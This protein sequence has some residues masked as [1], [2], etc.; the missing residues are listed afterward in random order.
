MHKR[1]SKSSAPPGLTAAFGRLELPLLD[2]AVGKA[3][4]LD[5]CSMISEDTE[6]VT[7]DEASSSSGDS[8]LQVSA[9]DSPLVFGKSYS[10]PAMF[11][12]SAASEP[13]DAFADACSAL[14]FGKAQSTQ[15]AST[16]HT[17]S[18]STLELR[19]I[20]KESRC[21]V[22]TFAGLSSLGSLL[23]GTGH[24]KPCAWFWKTPGCQNEFQCRHCHSC[25]RDALKDRRRMKAEAFKAGFLQPKI[26]EGMRISL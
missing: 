24:C 25:P 3:P 19:D 1:E 20:F 8:A 14:Q 23:H 9:V 4:S 12:G 5:G 11:L 10:H 16:P 7:H 6:I 17:A 21:Q 2:K 26:R 18:V 15:V 22:K 13:L